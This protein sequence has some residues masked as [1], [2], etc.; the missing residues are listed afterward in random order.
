M[1]K[2]GGAVVLHEEVG[3]P[4]QRVGNQERQRDPPPAL[5]R[6]GG[7]EQRPSRQR[8]GKVNGPRARVAVRAYVLGPEGCEIC[9]DVIHRCQSLRFGVSAF[10]SRPPLAG[11]SFYFLVLGPWEWRPRFR[12]KIQKLRT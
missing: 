4:S 1:F 3:D 10:V 11:F 9:F 6:Y 5:Q 2:R 8:P 12:V 7:D